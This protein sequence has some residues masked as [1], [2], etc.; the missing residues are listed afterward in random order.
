MRE[1]QRP[2]AGRGKLDQSDAAEARA[3]LCKQR[4]ENLLQ[5]LVDRP[6]HRHAVENVFADLDQAA[7]VWIEAGHLYADSLRDPTS[8]MRCFVE[9]DALR[10]GDWTAFVERAKAQAGT[11]SP[12]VKAKLE[13]AVE[14]MAEN[15]TQTS[16]F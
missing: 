1:H 9:A 16:M 11:V 13:A 4:L 8:A 7:D 14:Q 12:E 5:A 2:H 3:A 15:L 6:H 10:P